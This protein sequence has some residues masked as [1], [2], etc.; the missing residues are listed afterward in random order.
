MPGE[1]FID[2]RRVELRTLEPEDVGF[3]KRGRNNP[4]IARFLSARPLTQPEAEEEL[5]RYLESEG[6]HFVLVPTE[7]RLSGEP[8][9]HVYVD[10]IRN[11]DTGNLGVWVLPDAQR[12]KFTE[13]GLVHL[14]E[15]AFTELGLRRLW[16]RTNEL[17]RVVQRTAERA[18]FTQEGVLRESEYLDGEY[19]DGIMYAMLAREWMGRDT[20]LDRLYDE[21]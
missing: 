21:S 12:N 20:A 16:I 18:G 5:Q 1:T 4:S 3:I 10:P 6:V 15:Y 8:I 17:N 13:E 19:R 9:G 14:I 11:G 2:G 7:G